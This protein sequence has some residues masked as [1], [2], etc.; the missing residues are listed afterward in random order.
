MCLYYRRSSYRLNISVFTQCM[1]NGVFL[2]LSFLDLKWV[3]PHTGL[4]MT[5]F[6][7]AEGLVT[8]ATAEQNNMGQMH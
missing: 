4:F 8:K 3:N 1:L 2:R 5:N 7:F 6:S